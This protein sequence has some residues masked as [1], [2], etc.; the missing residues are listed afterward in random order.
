MP[1]TPRT[2]YMES[3]RTRQRQAGV[4]RVSVTLTAAEFKRMTQ[5]AQAQ[6]EKLTTHLKTLATAQLETRYLVPPDVAERL[7]TAVAILRG[8][9]NN[10]NQLARHANEM[11]YFLDTEEVRLQVKRMEDA[12]R[13]FVVSPK[14]VEG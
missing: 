1:T 9:G 2:A 3:F 6:G 11:R 12:V 7:D 5:S 14:R 13:E 8:I 10:L 4:R